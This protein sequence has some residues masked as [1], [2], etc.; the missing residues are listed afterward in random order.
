MI[1]PGKLYITDLFCTSIST[2]STGDRRLNVLSPQQLLVSLPC[3]PPEETNPRFEE[4]LGGLRF[5]TQ[6]G[7]VVTISAWTVQRSLR[8]IIL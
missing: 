3:L 1:I 2:Q 7:T 6:E 5:L 4:L 8:E